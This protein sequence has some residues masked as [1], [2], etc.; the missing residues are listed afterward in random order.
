MPWRKESV[1][2]ATKLD[3]RRIAVLP[4]VSMSPDPND[5]YFADG[6]TE[7]LITRL[8]LLR[9]LEVIARTS[10]MNYKREKK[11]VSQIGKELKV[12]TLLEGSVRKAGNRIRVSAQLIDAN[13]ESHL[14]AD[15]YDRDLQDIFEVQSSVAENV[16]RALKL[17]LLDDDRQKVE[18]TADMQAYTMYLRGTQLS[19]EASPASNREA[20]ALFERAILKDPRFAPAHAQLALAWVRE[21]WYE[22]WAYCVS[23]AEAAARKA[24]EL[25]PE[26][27]EAHAAMASVHGVQDRFEE[28]RLEA[29]TAIKINPNLAD[30]SLKLGWFYTALGNFEEAIRCYRKALSLDPLATE[31]AIYLTEILRV[32]AMVDEALAVVDE[33]REVHHGEG[34]VYYQSAMCYLQEKDYVKALDVLST[35]LKSFPD[36]YWLRMA[37]GRGYALSGKRAEALNELGDLMKDEAES[38]RLRAQVMI[39]TAL[40]D[41][42]EAFAALM[43]E[44]ELHSEDNVIRFDSLYERLWRD[45][46]FSEFCKKLGL[47][48][49]Q[50]PSSGPTGGISTS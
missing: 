26:S 7:E 42:D 20:I 24:L 44:A 39:R 50:R 2:S 10:A 13:T 37:R 6:L 40:G 48:T 12:G 34:W 4:F 41:L 23:R 30:A 21:R 36:D 15:S 1:E 43:R 35:G 17:R 32:A 27:A 18:S 14:W 22:D 11:S 49:L 25:E 8:S 38:H 33:L 9:G 31:P 5:E 3:A 29:E 46:R 47:P 16:A 28:L 19:R 45:P